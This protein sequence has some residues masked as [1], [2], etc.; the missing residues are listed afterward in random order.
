[1]NMKDLEKEDIN[2]V[3]EKKV[4]FVPKHWEKYTLIG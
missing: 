2:V 4:N 1:M 3:K